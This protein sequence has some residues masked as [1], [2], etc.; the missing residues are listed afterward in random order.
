MNQLTCQKGSVCFIVIYIA[1]FSHETFQFGSRE[2]FCLFRFVLFF[3][4][5]EKTTYW[6]LMVGTAITHFIVSFIH[7]LSLNPSISTYN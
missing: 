1:I 2:L 3:L 6:L 5:R 7:L 4:Y